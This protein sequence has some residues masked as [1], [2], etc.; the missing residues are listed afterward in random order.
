MSKNGWQIQNLGFRKTPFSLSGMGTKR[1]PISRP[2]IVVQQKDNQISAYMLFRDAERNDKVSIAFCKNILK[3]EW[4][5]ED[6]TTESVGSWEPT[7][8]TELWKNK[9]KLHVFIQKVEQIDGEGWGRV[10]P[11]MV[12]VLEIDFKKE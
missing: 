7:Y 10:P 6:I 3:P 1:I 8:D 2:Q 5:I 9:R 4:Q 12:R 11:Q